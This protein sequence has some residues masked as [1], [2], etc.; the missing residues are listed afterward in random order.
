[1]RVILP[2]RRPS[3]TPRC[4]ALHSEDAADIPGIT[5]DDL[6]AWYIE[7]HSDELE[8]QEEAL[9]TADLI[10]RII[11][12][13]VNKVIACFVYCVG[14][15]C[16]YRRLAYARPLRLASVDQRCRYA[17]EKL[18]VER[19]LRRAD[20]MEE[21][22]AEDEEDEVVYLFVSPNVDVTSINL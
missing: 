21:D 4:A 15:D 16:Q 7:E 14:I 9:E 19:K 2:L 3:L 17:Q 1:L 22:G 10:R 12:R 8:S 11:S 13:L 18:L 5:R 20:V 6:A